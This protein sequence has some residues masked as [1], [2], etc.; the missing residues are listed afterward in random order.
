M[1]DRSDR[2]VEILLVEDNERDA[3]L[4]LRALNRRQFGRNL[5]HVRDGAEALDFLF[6]TGPFV[7]RNI[8]QHPKVVLLDLKLPK[9]DGLEVLR[10]IKSDPKTRTI[11]VVI[12]TSSAEQRDLVASYEHGVNSY[13]VKPVDFEEFS[14]TMSELG[15]YW[16]L[17][18]QRPHE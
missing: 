2:D 10:A 7:G 13:I 3:E 4:A 18:N 12:L 16:L 8:R 5:L 17:L 15:G 1:L 6:G 11:P 9:I 14:Q